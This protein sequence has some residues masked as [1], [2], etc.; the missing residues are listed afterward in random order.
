[1]KNL[2]RKIFEFLGWRFRFMRP[3]QKYTD[4]ELNEFEQ[5]YR[6]TLPQD[7]RD[8]LIQTGVGCYT[9]LDGICLLEEWCQPYDEKEFSDD[10]LTHDFPHTEV[11]NDRNITKEEMGWRS[12]Y[13][14]NNLACG[15]MRVVNTGCEGYDLLI[16]SGP[17]RGNMWYDDRACSGKGIYPLRAKGTN[18]V[19]FQEYVR[20]KKNEKAFHWFCAPSGGIVRE[21]S[22]GSL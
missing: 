11:W 14:D 1:M 20:I 7:Y 5:K 6:I 10:F 18:R 9:D 15:A 8:Y 21:P 16:V 3:P 19:S 2:I 12:P 4:D 17:E 22:K 13:Y